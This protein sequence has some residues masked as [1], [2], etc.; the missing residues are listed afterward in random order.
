MCG[1]R[2]GAMMNWTQRRNILLAGVGVILMLLVGRLLYMQVIE[3]G[4]YGKIATDN[5]V[6]ILPIP[7][8]RGN[9]YDR[10][11]L[12][13]IQNRLSF[14]I[15]VLPSDFQGDM[16]RARLANILDLDRSE[17]DERLARRGGLPLE[18]VGVYRDADFRT[19]CRL[20]ER[21]DEFPGVIAGDEYVREYPSAGWAGHILGYVREVSPQQEQLHDRAGT[22]VRGLV[23]A[24]GIEKYYDDLLR[25]VD[26]VHYAQIN[27][28]GQLVGSMPGYKDAVPLA[29]ADLRLTLDWH[30]QELA[31]SLLAPYDA[32][33]V[34]AMDIKTGGILCFVTR[35]GYDPNVFSGVVSSSDWNAL[36]DNPLHPLLNRAL[37][38]LY[39]PGSTS[40]LATAGVALEAGA[41]RPGDHFK[42]CTGAYRFGNRTFRCWNAGGHGSLNLMGAIEQS[43]NIYFYQLIQRLDLDDWASGMRASGFG[44]V[45]GIDL[46]GE[47]K[48][49]VPDRAYYDK[50]YG[51]GKWSRGLTLNLAI[52]QGEFLV[53]PLQL[54]LHFAALAND[55]VAMKPHFLLAEREPDK[56][57]EF[58]ED[59][60]AYK[61]PYSQST[62]GIL[63]E[64]ARLVVQGD[65][66]TA[67]RIYD[68]AAPAAGK[69]GTAQNPHGKEHSWFVGYA[70]TDDPQI[71][72]VALVE[73][74]GHGS[75][76]AAP[77]CGTILSTYLRG[78]RRPNDLVV[79]DEE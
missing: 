35:P 36:R 34:V 40:K 32:G 12:P 42:A 10:N 14:A 56:N 63:Q 6:R 55:G 13:L 62:L 51:A 19:M 15:S 44:A 23:G 57:W 77:I 70:P 60:V 24:V 49:L 59:E 39:S 54:M 48:G 31:D 71:A 75:E 45:T 27:A 20:Q 41:V 74:A 8:P 37:K 16:A 58:H 28:L 33:T 52:G 50:R 73:N 47:S 76:F 30:L 26:G 46:P 3:S 79:A 29:G 68:K 25:G 38:G 2:R 17:L 5:R 9:V 11:G 78:G 66:G 61:L 22:P 72:I 64:A 53:T 21:L 43:C 67:R 1:V 18:P 7:A 69:T 65:H 4:Y